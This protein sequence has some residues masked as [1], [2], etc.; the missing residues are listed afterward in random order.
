MTNYYETI[1][2]CKTTIAGREITIPK[3][4]ELVFIPDCGQASGYAVKSEK[5]LMKL[6]AWDD[7]QHY[8]AYIPVNC[9]FAAKLVRNPITEK[10]ENWQD[11]SFQ[12]LVTIAGQ[13]FDYYTGSAKL[14]APSYDDVVHCLLIDS[15]AL[16]QDFEEW[17]SE[18]GYDADSRKA[19]KIWEE[20]C[21]NTRKLLKTGIDIAAERIRLQD[22]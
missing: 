7:A 11:T 2:K 13:N 21:K 14:G 8:H 15:N 10:S 17:A 12:W 9:V 4:T 19:Y 3:G 1:K 22:Y 5:T 20:C 6:G 18:Y 16:E